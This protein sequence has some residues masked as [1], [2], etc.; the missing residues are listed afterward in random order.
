MLA[1]TGVGIL[2]V[3]GQTFQQESRSE[4]AAGVALAAASATHT[5]DPLDFPSA[6]LDD[7]VQQ[8][9]G[10]CHNDALATGNLS[11]QGFDVGS[12]AEQSETAQT[13]EKMIIKLRAGLMPPPGMPRPAGDTLLALVETLEETMDEAYRAAPSPGTRM[14]QRLNRAEYEAAIKDLLGMEI[15]AADYLP[16]DPRSVNFDNIADAQTLSPTLLD[17]YLRAAGTISRV[18]IGVAD[19]RPTSVV[20]TNSGY[21]TQYDRMP[22]APRGTRGGVTAVHNFPADGEYVFEMWFEHT[23]TGNFMGTTLPGEQLD[24]SIDGEQV[25]FLELDRWMNPS[26]PQGASMSTPPIFVRA[27]PHRVSAAFLQLS[28]GPIEDLTS[29]HAWSMTDRNA[30]SSVY[31]LTNLAH[32]KDLYIVGPYN[33]TGVSDT[34]VRRKI[35]SCYPGSTDEERPCA[36]EIVSRLASEAFRRPVEQVEIESLLELYD[37]R[38]AVVGFEV[39]MRAA[40]QGILAMPDFVFRM[41]E[42]PAGS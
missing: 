25:A 13:A 40:L 9:C 24:I 12:A 4:S 28:G 20:Y 26:D 29:P 3:A 36:R 33:T 10:V 39:G 5:K 16:V 1:L 21:M 23:T 7:V 11:L 27:G 41:E 19:A 38:A 31:G 42:P 35:F 17:A 32:M 6:E 22:G 30:G 15:D 37:Q 8:Y 14:F 18:A 34:P 2:L